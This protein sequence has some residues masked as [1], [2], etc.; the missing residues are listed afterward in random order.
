MQTRTAPPQMQRRGVSPYTPSSPVFRFF[1]RIERLWDHFAVN[2]GALFKDARLPLPIES[3]SSRL[4]TSLRAFC[5]LLAAARKKTFGATP[6][7]VVGLKR[8]WHMFLIST[9]VRFFESVE[10]L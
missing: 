8:R 10:R 4:T 2:A 5:K 3:T 1:E 7:N 6:G 9:V